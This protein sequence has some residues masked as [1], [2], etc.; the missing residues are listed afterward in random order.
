MRVKIYFLFF[1]FN[2]SFNFFMSLVIVFAFI[3]FLYF[4]W[5]LDMKLLLAQN[6]LIY[7]HFIDLLDY[8]ITQ[9][10]ASALFV[11]A[12]CTFNSNV[13]NFSTFSFF[14]GFQCGCCLWGCPMCCLRRVARGIPWIGMT[15]LAVFVNFCIS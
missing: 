10:V 12:L 8:E 2:L 9:L 15:L 3:F 4:L 6:Y 7:V 5:Y 1:I 11:L 13:N 14:D